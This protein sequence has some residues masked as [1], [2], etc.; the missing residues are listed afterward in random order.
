MREGNGMEQQEDVSG[1][2]EKDPCWIPPDHVVCGLLSV[3]FP[4]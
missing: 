1:K 4:H 2:G 3:F